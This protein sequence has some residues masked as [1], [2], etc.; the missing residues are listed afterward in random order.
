MNIN[1]IPIILKLKF[2]DNL[3]KINY[4]KLL[5]FVLLITMYVPNVKE[6]IY[7]E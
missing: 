2:K 6:L 5:I 1:V 3:F 4:I 7:I